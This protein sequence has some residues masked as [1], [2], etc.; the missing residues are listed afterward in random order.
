[1]NE[2]LF[3]EAQLLAAIAEAFL[4][5]RRFGKVLRGLFV[6]VLVAQHASPQDEVRLPRLVRLKRR[7]QPQS[8]DPSW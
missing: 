3:H 2:R 1:V 8:S 7:V 5:F 4:D 6:V